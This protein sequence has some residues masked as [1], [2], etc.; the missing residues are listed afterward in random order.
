MSRDDFT[1]DTKI[2]AAKRV[3]YLCSCPTCRCY[4]ISASSTAD[5]ISLIG[6]AVHICAASKGGKRYDANMTADERKSINNCIWLCE[7]HAKLID[8]DEI[9][10]TVEL[11]KQW[12]KETEDYV[13]KSVQLNERKIKNNIYVFENWFRIFKIKVWPSITKDLICP[14]PMMKEEVYENFFQANV[15]LSKNIHNVKDKKLRQYLKGY[16]DCLCCLLNKFNAYC[17]VGS[18]DYLRLSPFRYKESKYKNADE[19]NKIET[20]I[21]ELG[22]EVTKYINAILNILRD[23]Y[24]CAFADEKVNIYYTSDVL[25]GYTSVIAEFKGGEDTIFDL[26]KFLIDSN[27]RL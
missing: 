2:K 16:Q 20:L 1:E 22:F 15:W 8:T 11:L 12:K 21:F 3:N 14:R 6:Q 26:N 27:K 4:T 9:E 23:E 5:G 25:E 10:Y 19:Y 18:L 7:N 24:N 13:R 17:E